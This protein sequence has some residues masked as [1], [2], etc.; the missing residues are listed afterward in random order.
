MALSP[1]SVAKHF[2]RLRDPRRNH[3]KRHLLIDI[4]VIALCAVLC[5]ANDW[6]QIAT[7]AQ[8]RHDWLKT[9]L[10]LPNGIPSHDTLERV[11]DRL[12]P[13]AFL[14]CF[15][16]WVEALTHALG[17]KHVAIDGKTLRHSGKASIQLKPLHIVSAWATEHSLT[18][19]QVAVDDKSNEITAIPQ[20]LELLD[21]QGALVTIDAMGCQKAIAKKIVAAG[22]DYV[23]S[24]KDNQPNLL[25]DIQ[26]TITEVLESGREGVEYQTYETTNKE[27]GREETRSYLLVTDLDKIRNRTEWADLKVVGMYTSTRRVAGK[28]SDEAHYFIGSRSADARVYGNALRR[29]WG[30]ENNLHWQLD[31]TFGEDANRVQRRHGA[32]NLA[33]LRRL[34]LSLLKRHTGKGSMACKRL[35]AA[36]DTAFLEEILIAGSILGNG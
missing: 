6:Q 11:F 35:S 23:L 25:A 17:L 30:I 19:G 29:H 2:A 28:V 8:R 21:V 34:A 15:Q 1:L 22:G 27:H 32:E 26:E 31:V 16:R 4:I 13:Q 24:V 5:G 7:F 3:C 36:L 9:F 12:D 10:A 20:L 33:L 18:L 14:G